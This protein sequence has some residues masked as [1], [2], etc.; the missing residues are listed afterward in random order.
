MNKKLLLLLLP[1]IALALNSCKGEGGG[2]G[3]NVP[4]PYIE[5]IT[6]DYGGKAVI[7]QPVILHGINFSPVASENKVLYGIGLDAKALRV[8]E[9]SEEHIVF[10]APDTDKDQIKIKVSVKGKESNSV[11]L[12]YTVLAEPII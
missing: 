6:T 9:S 10:N 3:D 2:G 5:S 4:E 1:A 8:S 12:E 7:G 11:V